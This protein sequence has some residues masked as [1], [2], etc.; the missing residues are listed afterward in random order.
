MS[1]RPPLVYRLREA[2][3]GVG[4]WFANLGAALVSPIERLVAA[5]G[6]KFF[7]ASE[8]LNEAD[9]IFL[10]IGRLLSWPFRMLWR[11]G[12]ILLP[13]S[14]RGAL[15]WPFV[16]LGQLAAGLGVGLWHLAEKLN[17]DGLM[18]WIAWLTTPIWR[19]LAGI[20]GFFYAWFATR[21]YKAL[22][23]G[24][25]AA[26]LL[27]PIA[28]SATWGL[29]WGS[30]HAAERYK[31][32]LR[33]AVEDKDYAR[34]RLYESKLTQLG[35]DTRHADFKTAEA[36]AEEG[37]EDEAYE[38]MQR[39]APVES[40][41]FAPAHA[42]I[43]QRLLA[44][45][46]PVPEADRL[47]L[48]GVHLD[49]LKL[50]GI[51]GPEIEFLRGVWLA[52]SDRL[53]EASE[54][55]GPLINKMP[56]A[57][58][59]RMR[60]DVMLNNGAEARRDAFA[61]RTHMQDAKRRGQKIDV[62]QYQ[63]WVVAEELLGDVKT[64]GPVV[65]EWHAAAPDDP[66]AKRSVALLDVRQ[67]NELVRQPNANSR[68][69]AD[70]IVEMVQLSESPA[71]YQ[72]Q[73]AAIFRQRKQAPVLDSL[74][75]E[76]ITAPETPLAVI[77]ALGTAAALQ[78]EI[79]LARQLLKRV[80]D[81]QPGN[82]VAWNNYGWALMQQPNP[83]LDLAQAAVNHSLAI[84]PEEF[85]FRET[86][87]QLFVLLGQWQP[88]VDDLEFALNGMPEAKPVHAALAL[89]YDKLGQADLA[90]MHREQAQ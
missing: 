88:A 90:Q 37:K 11:L 72:P 25:P 61:V 36:L 82:A 77:D 48:A 81:A 9:S 49:H 64:L 58:M 8:R 32:A 50:L 26:V 52:Q 13:E 23:W 69:L 80:V 3:A 16:K 63:S 39:L 66:A 45:K 4:Q 41:S 5:I 75:N 59:E 18:L 47:R 14:V 87:G 6:G 70:R 53:E 15:A 22:L 83:D 76:L 51:R 60:I 27:L 89:A 54:T 55:M 46:L 73:L 84:M 33:D 38:R 85:R 31:V 28:A 34:M 12:A 67:F 29:L 20:G 24:L 74:I 40:A 57:A 79:D 17:L 86:R 44:Q 10:A 19:P 21:Q 30:S 71:A 68:E 1:R 2:V 62:Q 42:W 65:R 35:A 56:Y 7:A 78:G 43:L